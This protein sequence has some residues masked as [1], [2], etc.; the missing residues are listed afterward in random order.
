[1][2][3]TH[4]RLRVAAF[5]VFALCMVGAAACGSGAEVDGSQGGRRA[6]GRRAT[7]G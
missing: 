4:S 1:M 5:A 3:E 6:G 7:D 2:P